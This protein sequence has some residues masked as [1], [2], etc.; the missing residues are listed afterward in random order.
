[1]IDVIEI[2]IKEFKENI[3]MSEDEQFIDITIW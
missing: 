1:M 2:T 3:Y